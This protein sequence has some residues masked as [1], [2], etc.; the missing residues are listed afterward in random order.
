MR[1]RANEFTKDVHKTLKD[2]MLTEAEF[3]ALLNQPIEPSTAV[4]KNV[5][6]RKRLRIGSD[7]TGW[8]SVAATL[9]SVNVPHRTMLACDIEPNVRKLLNANYK[10]GKV[11]KDVTLRKQK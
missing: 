1:R 11:Y 2:S 5:T 4:S 6:R 8:E 7:C 3:K 10:I 9:D